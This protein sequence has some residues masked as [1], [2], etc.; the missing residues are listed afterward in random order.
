MSK[1]PRQKLIVELL[2]HAPAAS[3]DDL[4]KL[5]A[6]EGFR[7]TQATLSRDIHELGL[8]KSNEGY[9]LP[10]SSAAAEV[11]SPKAARIVPEFV[12]G[13][14]EAQNLVVV[15]T[16]LG[17]AQPVA[18]ALDAE[19]WPEMLGS[20]AGD[21]TVLIITK[22]NRAAHALALRFRELLA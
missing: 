19:A 18:A 8:V 16:S 20:V 15:K 17:S 6:R 9:T 12:L 1:R 13:V 5:L 4:R 11:G 22:S 2:Q 14:H 21:D 10:G 7:V 3:Q